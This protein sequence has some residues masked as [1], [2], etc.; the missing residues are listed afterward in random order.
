MSRSLPSSLVIL[1]VPPG[2]MSGAMEEREFFSVDF[3][4]ELCIIVLD[5]RSVGTRFS[6]FLKTV[7]FRPGVL[8]FVSTNY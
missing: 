8:F 1:S 5:T 2:A 7:L 3:F 6:A 4:A